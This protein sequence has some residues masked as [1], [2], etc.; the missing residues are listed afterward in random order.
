MSL[1]R[2]KK[3][4]LSVK[5]KRPIGGPMV[6]QVVMVLLVITGW[7]DWRKVPKTWSCLN[8]M[9]E[10]FFLKQINASTKPH[11]FPK[12]D[13]KWMFFF[14][15]Y[16]VRFGTTWFYIALDSL[17]SICEKWSSIK[18]WVWN[19]VDKDAFVRCLWLALQSVEVQLIL[20]NEYLLMLLYGYFASDVVTWHGDFFSN[21]WYLNTVYKLIYVCGL[22]CA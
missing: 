15:F 14:F 18:Y 11:S 3:W 8:T 2:K 10:L 17:I 21:F 16:Y 5:G 7:V 4:E 12:L 9:L 13:N 1:K 22:T 20:M 19:P 6:P